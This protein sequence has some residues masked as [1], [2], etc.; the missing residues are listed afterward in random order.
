MLSSALLPPIPTQWRKQLREVM[1]T[2]PVSGRP[3]KRSSPSKDPAFSSLLCRLEC[4]SLLYHPHSQI[5][6]G[7]ISHSK[8]PAFPKFKSSLKNKCQV[9][10]AY[11]F[12]TYLASEEAL[13]RA[14]YNKLCSA[15]CA[16]SLCSA[17][18]C[19]ISTVLKIEV[20]MTLQF[21]HS[22]PSNYFIS[23]H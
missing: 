3:R 7:Q 19:V 10:I 12:I 16:S 9:T 15:N 2:Q 23:S 11:W 4:K 8:N 17:S 22:T 14:G 1:I 5:Q 18:S 13:N 20:S 21:L 6:N